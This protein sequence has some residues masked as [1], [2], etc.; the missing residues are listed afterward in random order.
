[1]S[2][3]VSN[4]TFTRIFDSSILPGMPTSV[5]VTPGNAQLII[6][7]TAP[8][9]N[10][11]SAITDYE[12]ST[13]GGTTFKLAGTTTSPFTITTVSSSSNPLVNGVIYNIQIRACNVNGASTATASI[14]AA[15]IAVPSLTNIELLRSSSTLYQ[16]DGTN[17]NLQ[18]YY[19]SD[20]DGGGIF[21]FN[22]S[23]LLQDDSATAIKPNN[24][25]SA[26][27]GRWIRQ[28]EGASARV[29]MWGARGN[30]ISNDQPFIQQAINYV[31]NNN[32]Y[33]LIFGSKTYVL[34]TLAYQNIGV[35][36]FHPKTFLYVGWGPI[37]SDIFA[38]PVAF[39]PTPVSANNHVTLKLKGS[40]ADLTKIITLSGPGLQWTGFNTD[41]TSMITLHE[42]IC[43]FQICDMTLQRQLTA[44]MDQAWHLQGNDIIRAT[45]NYGGG[46]RGPY[47][48]TREI[49]MQTELIAFTGVNFIDGHAAFAFLRSWRPYGIRRF[50]A[51]D[52]NFYYPFGSNSYF[53]EGGAP[54]VIMGPEVETAEFINLYWE[55]TPT[56]NVNSPNFDSKDG[57]T[58]YSGKNSL[59]L[60]CTGKNTSVETLYNGFNTLNREAVVNFSSNPTIKPPIGGTITFNVSSQVQNSF[61]VM[62]QAGD[63]ITLRSPFAFATPQGYGHYKINSI[64]D[65]TPPGGLNLNLK[66]YFL[67]CTSVSGVEIN[68]P[69]GFLNWGLLF[70]PVGT[71]FSGSSRLAL[72]NIDSTLNVSTSVINCVFLGGDATIIP[73]AYATA[74]G[75]LCA[76][77]SHNPAI[78]LLNGV[79]TIK[80]NRF[81][82]CSGVFDDDSE[83]SNFTR[84][85]IENNYIEIHNENPTKF[86]YTNGIVGQN[87]SPS[88]I[89]LM[90]KEETV[91]NN[92]F[93][94]WQN[95]EVGLYEQNRSG[96]PNNDQNWFVAV[97]Y[98]SYSRG[99]KQN[100]SN[101]II[102]INVPLSAFQVIPLYS[103]FGSNQRPG[104][105]GND[106]C[107]N[108]SYCVELCTIR[109]DNI[110]R[111]S[112]VTALSTLRQ[113]YW[114]NGNYP[115]PYTTRINYYILSANLGNLGTYIFSPTSTTSDDGNTV[116][117]PDF[118]ATGRWL[119]Q[120]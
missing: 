90:G 41:F 55:G 117:K 7:F 19:N 57:F 42:R 68:D 108:L 30:G 81:I 46:L 44:A 18:G 94:F 26:S 1:M 106:F 49:D 85:I 28:F 3:S 31:S 38:G 34:S 79:A 120:I 77:P 119:K 99:Y 15:P 20:D 109:I 100:I 96:L 104:A 17:I 16:T 67:S 111:Y 10:G 11:G 98:N 76:R 82:K 93:V 63:Y 75:G 91:R 21:Q 24:I 118:I 97:G 83:A 70:C 116:I 65:V 80:N 95:S 9:F 58:L 102:E 115:D 54:M 107:A 48:T 23:S 25:A 112:N 71:P 45:T 56:P 88:V 110:I 47:G 5:G 27:P 72:T 66:N 64:Q 87:Y 73:G 33:E 92:N 29:E 51:K 13:D 105:P 32:I 12:Y 69:E 74:H 78:R 14:A 6:S 50:I 4:L 53:T 114:Y 62:Y 52:C 35:N 8:S 60:N 43:S 86:R 37:P 103:Q 22:S 2:F 36:N 101:N 84:G 59:F 61:P 39:T 113:I 40:G 89:A